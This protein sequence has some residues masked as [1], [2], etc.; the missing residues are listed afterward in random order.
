M[1]FSEVN[2][3]VVVL[4]LALG[5]AILIIGIIQGYL[6]TAILGAVMLA[7]VVWALMSPKGN[8]DS[9]YTDEGEA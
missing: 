7:F 2:V 5:A 1:P 8:E 4:S 9:D 6:A 3:C